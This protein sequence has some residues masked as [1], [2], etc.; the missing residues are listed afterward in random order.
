MLSGDAATFLGHSTVLLESA[1]SRF[2]TDPVLRE[3][4]AHLRRHAPPVAQEATRDLDAIL[5]SH[6]HHDHLDKRSLKLLD[7]STPGAATASAS[8]SASTAR[9]G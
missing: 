9:R 7:R 5:I 6:L 3:R 4:L 2:L 1:G 8:A